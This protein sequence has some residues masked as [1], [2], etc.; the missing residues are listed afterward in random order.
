MGVLATYQVYKGKGFDK[1]WLW[2]CS[3]QASNEWRCTPSSAQIHRFLCAPQIKMVCAWPPHSMNHSISVFALRL[4]LSLPCTHPFVH[5]VSTRIL[6]LL[7]DF[8]HFC[9]S[10]ASPTSVSSSKATFPSYN[11]RQLLVCSY[12]RNQSLC[13][14][15]ERE[16][17]K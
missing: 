12:T 3:L 8:H 6:S 14:E 10:P 13:Q 17:N 1:G 7:A 9:F 5:S 16:E 2:G 11:V 4:S 15:G